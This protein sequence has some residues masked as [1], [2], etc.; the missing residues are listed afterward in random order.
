MELHDRHGR[1]RCRSHSTFHR[2]RQRRH[3]RARNQKVAATFSQAMDPATISASGTFTVVTT[4][5]ATPVPGTVTYDTAS[6]TAIFT[7]SA[8]FATSTE[9]TA[10]ISNA[11]KD[12]SGNAL[13]AGERSESVELHDR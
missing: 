3:N 1:Y 10:T 13:I 7:P 5:G 11:A 12:L 9:F 8:N 2:S 6:N 4:I